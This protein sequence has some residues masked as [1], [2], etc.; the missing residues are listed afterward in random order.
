[1][2]AFISFP[3]FKVDPQYMLVRK[4]SN[5]RALWVEHF[6]PK[7]DCEATRH[8]DTNIKSLSS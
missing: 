8:L 5:Q 1:M 4:K 7:H 3:Y 6:Y 2:V